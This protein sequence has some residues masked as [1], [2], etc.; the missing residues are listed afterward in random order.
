M[1][2]R[3]RWHLYNTSTRAPY[4]VMDVLTNALHPTFSTNPMLIFTKTMLI[5]TK[6]VLE[7][8]FSSLI[9]P[10]L[11]WHRS[12][13]Y[14]LVGEFGN[15]TQDSMPKV[16]WQYSAITKICCKVTAVHTKIALIKKCCILFSCLLQSVLASVKSFTGGSA[17]GLVSRTA[18]L[19]SVDCQCLF[20]YIT[21]RH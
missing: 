1:S 5:F 4:L 19:P 13:Y 3:D 10:K 18:A 20:K 11:A 21:H 7:S 2:W 17:R 16:S 15:K 6:T 9:L 12:C 14:V 8:P